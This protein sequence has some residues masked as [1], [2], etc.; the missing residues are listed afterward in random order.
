MANADFEKHFV[1]T[2]AERYE[3]A[4]LKE[5]LI[6]QFLCEETYSDSKNLAIL[7]GLGV[8]STKLTLEKMEQKGLLQSCLVDLIDIG[9]V[10][11]YW[12]ITHDGEFAAWDMLLYSAFDYEKNKVRIFEKRMLSA[13]TIAHKMATQEIILNRAKVLELIGAKH[14]LKNSFIQYTESGRWIARK[15]GDMPL[16]RKKI[17]LP[18]VV[19][20]YGNIV[21][22]VEAELSIKSKERYKTTL[23]RYLFNVKKGINTHV[24]YV[25]KTKNGRIA[26]KA[27][28]EAVAKSDMELREMVKTRFF[29]TSFAELTELL[30]EPSGNP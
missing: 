15:E 12:G 21:W 25:L 17:A 13:K 10:K 19:F 24:L 3:K 14:L 16:D 1:G 30:G 28:L 8:Q 29:Y 9:V 22:G 4:R 26:F 5:R 6:L 7:I 23:K 27:M 18:D 2:R 11:K 20:H